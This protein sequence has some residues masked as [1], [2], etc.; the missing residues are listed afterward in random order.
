[1]SSADVMVV[2]PWLR[3]KRTGVSIAV[4]PECRICQ[5]EA[6]SVDTRCPGA[7]IAGALE[8]A[9]GVVGELELVALAYEHAEGAVAL[10]VVGRRGRE[11]A[12]QERDGG[13]QLVL[14]LL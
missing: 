6:D 2:G 13:V 1:M 9:D 12:A 10:A 8:G 3:R 14:G 4:L 7:R 5:P 11:A